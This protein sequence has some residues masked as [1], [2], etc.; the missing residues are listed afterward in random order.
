MESVM[1]PM[2]VTV[3]DGIG[4]KEKLKLTVIWSLT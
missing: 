4:G 1:M 3:R 2:G